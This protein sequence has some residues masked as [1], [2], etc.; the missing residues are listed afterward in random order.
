MIAPLRQDMNRLHSTLA[1]TAPRVAGLPCVPPETIIQPSLSV[2]GLLLRHPFFI[3]VV[4]GTL[5]DAAWEGHPLPFPRGG[6][7]LA[8]VY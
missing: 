5:S 6:S 3:L 4:H 8:Q 7:R 1:A 2:L